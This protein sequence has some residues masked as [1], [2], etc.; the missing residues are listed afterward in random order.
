VR[1][2][3]QAP[4]GGLLDSYLQ[5]LGPDG[6]ELIRDDDGGVSLNSLIEEYILPETGEYTIV[7]SSYGSNSRGKLQPALAD[8]H[9]PTH[10]HPRADAHPRRRA[11][12]D[13]P[14]PHRPAGRDRAGRPVDVRGA[15]GRDRT[16]EMQTTTPQF[17]DAYLELVSP[18]GLT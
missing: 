2:D 9:A 12:P 8:R 11:D 7:S 17:L 3:M 18:G 13:R 5:L 14:E 15:P 4:R 6:Q 16:I 1:I 10:P